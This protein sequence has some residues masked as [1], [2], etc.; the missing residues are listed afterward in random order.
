M[1]GFNT[2]NKMSENEI[3]FLK[4]AVINLTIQNQEQKELIKNIEKS[5]EERWKWYQDKDKELESYKKEQTIKLSKH[6]IQSGLNRV[7]HAEG[8]I[9]QLP[10]NHEGRNTWLLN[11]GVKKQAKDFREKRDLE[12]E[13][14]TQSCQAVK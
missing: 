4:E 2:L 6:E 5:A 7:K 10:D 1:E 12:F 9:E 3:K 8:L 13:E 11:Y 14:E